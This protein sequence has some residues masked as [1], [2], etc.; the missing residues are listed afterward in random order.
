V[1]G[2]SGWRLG[3]RFIR[4]VSDN[5]PFLILCMSGKHDKTI[6]GNP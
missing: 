5:R 2:A 3:M 4:F 6:G 1:T